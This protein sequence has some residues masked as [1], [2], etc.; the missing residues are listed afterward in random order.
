MTLP[1]LTL[2]IAR[3]FTQSLTPQVPPTRGYLL[4]AG[5]D[6]GVTHRSDLLQSRPVAD[7]QVPFGLPRYPAIACAAITTASPTNEDTI[8]IAVHD[9]KVCGTVIPRY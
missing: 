5:S 7:Y 8:F 3:S 9:F 1:T 6:I 4:H 2:T